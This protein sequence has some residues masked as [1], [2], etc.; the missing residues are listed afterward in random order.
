VVLPLWLRPGGVGVSGTAAWF[1]GQPPGVVAATMS[2]ALAEYLRL[3]VWPHPLA[4]DF[5]YSMRIPYTPWGAPSSLLAA[6]AWGS[7]LATGLLSWRMAPVRAAGILWVFVALLPVS[8]VI[9]TGV[10]M[11]ERLLYLPSV[12]F[13]LWVGHGFAWA[14][15]S[16]GTAHRGR[17]RALTAAGVA[18]L[19]AC[20]V[21]VLRRNR[22]WR[23]MRALW[24]AEVVN[25]PRDPVV[26]NNLAVALTGA[27]EYARSRERL[28]VALEVA[29]LYWRAWVN[30][31][32]LEQRT[33]KLDAALRDFQRAS[34][35]DPGA[36]SPHLFAGMALA[37]A[38][39]LAEA[40][41]RFAAAVRLA[42]EDFWA[43]YR[44]GDVLARL[45]RRAEARDEFRR[46]LALDPRS[47]DARRRL[48]EVEGP[49]V[50]DSPPAAPA[51]GTPPR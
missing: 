42:P 8:N 10:L 6:V 20:G 43:R 3:L 31:G 4:V 41:A 18:V 28:A 9:P 27:G 2:R 48:A 23:D 36:S 7:V 39:R 13:C 44:H 14:L 33:G 38:G 11:A 34:E 25:T 46:A 47:E 12:G 16:A 32:I 40:E 35:I 1:A 22:D 5:Y 19:L 26:N 15:E 21:Q 17:A 24:E 30:L 45:G 37:D 49:G 50:V 51:A 29:P